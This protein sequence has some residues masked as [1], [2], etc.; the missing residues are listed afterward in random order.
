MLEFDVPREV[1][2]T[3]HV[4]I[5]R[6]QGYVFG[7]QHQRQQG[8]DLPYLVR[9]AQPIENLAE[10]VR[11]AIADRIQMPE[12]ALG[13]AQDDVQYCLGGR[14]DDG[15]AGEDA[16]VK[17]LAL[18][19]HSHD[20]RRGAEV[21]NRIAAADRLRYDR[22]VRRDLVVLLSASRGN[23]DAGNHFVEYQQAT[24]IQRHFAHG[25]QVTVTRHQEPGISGDGLHHDGGD[26]VA[27]L[28]QATLQSV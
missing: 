21:G 27:V 9:H 24:A 18:R 12:H 19:N 4:P 6:D 5:I 14:H 26:V 25:L 28:G 2:V 22:N 11:Q 3:A 15:V 8:T 7:G 16:P 17:Q 10:A 13:V 20:V 1:T 23:A